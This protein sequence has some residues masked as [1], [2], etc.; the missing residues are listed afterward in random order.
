AWAAEQGAVAFNLYFLVATGRGARLADLSPAD[1]ETLL[2]EL[3]EHQR[4]Y[5]GRMLVRAKCAP[6]FMRHVHQRDPDSTILGYE[7]RCP[8]GVQY[9][10]ITPDGKLTPCPYIPTAAGDLRSQSFGEIWREAPLFGELRG[11]TLGGKCGQCEYRKLCGGCRARAFAIEGDLLAADP[12]CAYQPDPSAPVLERMRPVTYGTAVA[13]AMRWSPEA[14][15]RLERIP[16]FVRGVI[17]ARLESYARER[18]IEEITPEL[19][20]EVR[21]AMPVDF[22]S[23]APFFLR[24]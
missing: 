2:G 13:T 21:K 5:R 7:T 20:L 17:T 12:S 9:C 23:R 3:A 8:C 4:T 15:A 18:G 1:Y 22:S 10:R 24:K 16:S 19:M 14:S 11:G 6:H